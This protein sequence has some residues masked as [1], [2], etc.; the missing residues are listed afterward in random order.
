MQ[1]KYVCKHF[2]SL[3]LQN[4]REK[5]CVR[6]VGFC[7]GITICVRFAFELE[8]YE[9]FVW[10]TYVLLSILTDLKRDI[11][12]DLL[13]KSL[14]FTVGV[15]CW[16]RPTKSHYNLINQKKHIF[17]GFFFFL[18]F[19]II[20]VWLIIQKVFFESCSKVGKNFFL[21]RG[22]RVELGSHTHK[23]QSETTM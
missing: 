6:F 3:S 2:T 13:K 21:F 20:I 15:A 18:F 1:Q 4:Y 12:V 22:I 5:N 8:I 16:K 19:L 7:Q 10:T 23:S 11:F 14:I 17:F 9:R